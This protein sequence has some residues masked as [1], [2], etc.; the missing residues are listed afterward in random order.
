MAINIIADQQRDG[1]F[2][3]E[4]LIEWIHL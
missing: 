4:S 1:L 3:P 2:D